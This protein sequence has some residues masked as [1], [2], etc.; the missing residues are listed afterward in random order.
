MPNK[1][2]LLF[3]AAALALAA[4]SESKV[5]TATADPDSEV[6][7]SIDTGD[8]ETVASEGGKLEVKL[9]GGVEAKVDMPEGLGD[10]G[11]FSI[12]GVGLYPGAKVSAIAINADKR[13][14][15]DDRPVVNFG[16]SAPADAA[17]VADWYQQ[18]FAD[19][20]VV[21]QRTGETLTGKTREGD[22]F[23]LALTPAANG[24]KGQMTIRDAG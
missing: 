7:I 11:K 6:K 24:S 17:A 1:F 19:K 5:E 3:A 22:D 14:G 13:S 9:P 20:K 23:T 15:E 4:C 21:V 2:P 10:G 18:Q 12:A 8:G 16:F